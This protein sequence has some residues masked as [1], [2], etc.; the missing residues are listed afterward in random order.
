MFT[1]VSA[2]AIAQSYPRK[3]VRLILSFPP[4]GGTDLLGRTVAQKLSEKWRQPVIVDNRA[5]GNGV[6]GARAAITAAPDGYTLYVGSSEHLILAPNL[7]NNLPYDTLRDLIPVTSLANQYFILVVH[8]SV[9][10]TSVKEFIALAKA[11]PGKLNFASSGTGTA[12][13]LTGEFFQISTGIKMTHVPYKGSGPAIADLLAGRDVTTSFAGVA[14]VVPHIKSGRLRP[15]FLTSAQ[16]VK[17]LPDVATAAELGFP[18]VVIY[19]WNGIFAPIGTNKALVNSVSA[20]ISGILRMPDV[21]ERLAG[22]GLD[23]TGGTPEQFTEVVKADLQRWGKII[24]DS[25]IEKS[26]L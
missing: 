3:P 19:S 8:P 6:V 7:F 23:P 25:G 1:L 10:A 22:F 24:K 17:A 20:D 15:L 16:R 2:A 26:Q 5:G 11:N 12:A 18:S 14:S 4:G 9:P 13:H 21:S